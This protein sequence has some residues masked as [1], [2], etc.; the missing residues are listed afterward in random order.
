MDH[1][2]DWPYV[3]VVPSR[4][5]GRLGEELATG[6][7]IE[8]GGRV[9]GRNVQVDGG[10][11]DIVAIIHRRRT[12]IEVRSLR[13]EPGPSAV[14]PLEA[15]DATKARQVRRLAGSIGCSRVDLI[16]IRFWRR[17]VDLHWV[18]NIC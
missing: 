13:E 6:F 16:A 11:V 5:L 3:R 1:G 17:G 14:N 2:V 15:F 18:P 12:A 10:E 9:I 7:I 8:R 4:Q